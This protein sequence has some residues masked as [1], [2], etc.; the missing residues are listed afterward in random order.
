MIFLAP[1]LVIYLSKWQQQC[2]LK[3][4]Q[5]FTM[6][7]T[8]AIQAIS[9]ALGVGYSVE[10][11]I[12][13]ARKELLLLYRESDRIVQE[14]MYM[15]RQLKMNLSIEKVLEEFAERVQIEEVN[16]FI[17]VFKTAK[18]TGG[19]QI[20]IIKETVRTLRESV[21]VKR[22][23]QTILAAKKF[24]FR[25]M[26][27]IPFAI[28]AYMQLAFPEFMSVLYGTVTGRI[29]MTICLAVDA[30]AYWIGKKVMEI[31]I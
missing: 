18:R 20:A 17:T 22:E 9:V 26:T 11:S 19:D 4:K 12:R 31:A 13:E 1:V 14:F 7:F 15:E 21:E 16:S 29:V 23:I 10:N 27:V 2:I 28:L 24:E 30:A 25:I 6:Q 3:R 8:D 5:E